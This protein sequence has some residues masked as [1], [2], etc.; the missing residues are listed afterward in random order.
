[1]ADAMKKRFPRF[2]L[3]AL[4]IAVLAIA[5]CW[6]L[7]ATWGVHSIFDMDHPQEDRWQKTVRG[8]S[9][10]Y[11][12]TAANGDG[13][14]WEYKSTAFLPFLIC[15]REK[16]RRSGTMGDAWGTENTFFWFFGVRFRVSGKRAFER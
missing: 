12:K 14:F 11:E 15:T 7:T 16:A 3:R 6:T 8:N 10:C 9:V 4:V 1:M 13:Y 2:S 5:V